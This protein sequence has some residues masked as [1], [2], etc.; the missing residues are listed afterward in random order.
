M[1]SVRLV[2]GKSRVNVVSSRT[3]DGRRGSLGS[4]G[5]TYR[6]ATLLCVSTPSWVESP[7]SV[8]APMALLALVFLGLATLTL[9]S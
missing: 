7:S 2:S 8:R 5:P 6:E 3:Q 9:A 4:R 1:R